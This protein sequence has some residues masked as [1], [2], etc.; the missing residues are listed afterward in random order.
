MSVHVFNFLFRRETFETHPNYTQV[1]HSIF[2][3]YILP[4]LLATKHTYTGNIEFDW[5]DQII[6]VSLFFVSPQMWYNKKA[7]PSLNDLAFTKT[8][9]RRFEMNM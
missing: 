1:T 3:W 4:Y 5:T 6:C 9:S 8:K 2:T 7:G